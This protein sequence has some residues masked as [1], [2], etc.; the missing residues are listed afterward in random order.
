MKSVQIFREGQEIPSSAKYLSG[1]FSK[2]Q[3]CYLFFYEVSTSEPT[4]KQADK[5]KEQI[6]EVIKYLNEKVAGEYT[7][8]SKTTVSKIRARFNEGRTVE[9]LKKVID[10]KSQE[11]LGDEKWEPYLRPET[12]FGPK[13]DGYLSASSGGGS[14]DDALDELEEFLKEDKK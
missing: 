14:R 6:E 11:W 8:K 1:L 7:T 3:G 13:F 5:F 12:L 10:S 2:T 9:Q 4:K